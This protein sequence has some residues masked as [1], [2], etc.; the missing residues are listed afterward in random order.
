ME[1]PD[2]TRLSVISFLQH[3]LPAAEFG[4]V[5]REASNWFLDIAMEAKCPSMK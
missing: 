2:G 3:D 4:S 5:L 1:R